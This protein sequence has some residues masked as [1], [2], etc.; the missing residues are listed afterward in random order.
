MGQT[1]LLVSHVERLYLDEGVERFP[2]HGQEFPSDIQHV[3]LRAR[4]HHSDQRVVICSQALKK[5]TIQ[6]PPQR[7][8]DTPVRDT[9]VFTRDLLR[10]LFLIRVVLH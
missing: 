4:H 3:Y 6:V 8:F 9:K 1:Q 5:E 2:V 10:D 7:L